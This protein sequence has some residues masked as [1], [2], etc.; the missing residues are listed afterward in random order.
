MVSIFF[1][2]SH[3][4]EA[5]RDA[6]EKHLAQLKRE[7]AIT[8]WYDRRIAAGDPI[9]NS[10]SER[11]ERAEI[12]LLLVSSDFL[13]SEYCYGVEMK[14]AIERHEAGEARV[15]PI[16]LRPCDWHS[17]P[18]GRI[19][20]LPT[21]AKPV[22]K[23]ADL[24]DAFLDI[25]K[26]IRAALPTLSIPAPEMRSDIVRTSRQ[27]DPRSSNLRLRKTFTE[28]D[29]DAF[30]DTTF[31]YMARY[32]ENSLGELLVRNE[33]VEGSFKR[34]DATRFTASIY[35]NGAAVARCTIRLGG[36][37]GG[38]SLSYGTNHSENSMNESLSTEVDD[39]EMYLKSLGMH[40]R[41]PK[42]GGKLSQEGAAEYYWSIFIAPLQH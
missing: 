29:R 14:R 28:R 39:Q 21:D 31:E 23:W 25:A 15:I 9:D 37:F 7:G 26:G 42:G 22:T 11:L 19:L 17:A 38:I 12:I 24:D 2:Y 35:R 5:L 4:D 40:M 6:L 30:L 3:A 33:G 27:D 32:F 13:S 18:F 20:A 8:T 1:S 16:I 34:L 36:A 41:G 10:V